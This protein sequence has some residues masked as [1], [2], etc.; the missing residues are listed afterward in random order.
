MLCFLPL[1]VNTYRCNFAMFPKSNLH[2]PL[3]IQ[4]T[5]KSVN[6]YHTVAADIYRLVFQLLQCMKSTVH[7]LKGM[8]SFLSVCVWYWGR[9]RV[10]QLVKILF[11]W[12]PQELPSQ[13]LSFWMN[14]LVA[15]ISWEI[16]GDSSILIWL[17]LEHATPMWAHTGTSHSSP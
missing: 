17:I 11:F 8:L 15:F 12:N 4:V 14:Q 16:W 10:L 13:Y 1:S 7:P 3:S 6:L 5:P 2:I 9:L